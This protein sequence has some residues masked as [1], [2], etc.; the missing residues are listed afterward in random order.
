MDRKI[1]KNAERYFVTGVSLITS[2]GSLGQNVMAAEW[3]MQ[4]SYEPML[5]AVFVHSSAATFKNIKQ[6]KEFGVNVATD[7]QTSLV[8][9]AGGYS[10]REIDKLRV[11]DSFKF[12]KSKYIK[13]PMIAGCI[14]NVECKLVIMKKLGDHTMIV[15]KAIDIRYDKT[16]KPLV[17]HV[18]RYHQLGSVI[19]PF[20]H[21]V[22]VNK[23]VF[24]WFFAESKGKFVLRCV[25]VLIKAGNRV[26]VSSYD[27]KGRAYETIPYI[28]P[29]RGTDNMTDIQDHLKKSG[30]IVVLRPDPI[31]K[32]LILQ[33][34]K[35]IQR[36]NFV[37]F[38]G[39]LKSGFGAQRKWK[40]IKS[41]SMLQRITN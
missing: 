5:I 14:V 29:K 3:T 32:R 41:D 10:R 2:T 26:L 25:G 1:A 6:T 19:E 13:A 15:G 39:K 36:I 40:S 20:R 22:R 35:R 31:L 28:V 17:Y 37:L 16:K 12:L 27:A 8:N 7:K 38:E 21:I 11:K 34:K 4:I 30:L 33:Y 18:G 24:D 9:I 23:F